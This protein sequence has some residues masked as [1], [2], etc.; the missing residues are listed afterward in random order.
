MH[1]YKIGCLLDFD[2][3]PKVLHESKHKLTVLASRLVFVLFL[4]LAWFWLTA[5]PLW[6]MRW[7]ENFISLLLEVMVKVTERMQ[8]HFV[9]LT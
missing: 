3:R 4:L 9:M 8:K 1:I 2:K 6:E 7:E 5:V